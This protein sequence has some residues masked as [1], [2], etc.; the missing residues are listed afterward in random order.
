MLQIWII[1]R[2]VGGIRIAH[3]GEQSILRQCIN[4]INVY[5]SLYYFLIK[6]V[7][8][9]VGFSASCISE[10]GIIFSPYHNLKKLSE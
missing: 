4:S 3:F 5:L 6:S 9:R 7:L 10:V 1:L 8:F 2:S